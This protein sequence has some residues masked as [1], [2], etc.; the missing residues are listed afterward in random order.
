MCYVCDSGQ[1]SF[2]CLDCLRCTNE[3]EHYYMVWDNIWN[4][5]V[6]ETRGMLCFNCLEKRLG[7]KLTLL[8]FPPYPVNEYHI[9]K[10]LLGLNLY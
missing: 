2:K 8:D 9:E 1:S 10:L 6:I 3:L 4:Q 5:A 7:R